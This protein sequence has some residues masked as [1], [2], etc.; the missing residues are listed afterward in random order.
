MHLNMVKIT[1]RTSKWASDRR[2]N[3]ISL[4]KMVWKKTFPVS[5]SF[6]AENTSGPRKWEKKNTLNYGQPKMKCMISLFLSLSTAISWLGKTQSKHGYILPFFKSVMAWDLFSWHILGFSF[7]SSERSLNA[8]AELNIISDLYPFM[9]AML[10]TGNAPRCKASI[11]SNCFLEHNNEV[12]VLCW[13]GHPTH[14]PQMSI[15]HRTF[16]DAVV[17]V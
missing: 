10:R 5:R 7:Y 13:N 11:T 1:F 14:R 12:T 8:I 4:M 6:M 2:G 3:S 17:N 15:P 16:W 9:S